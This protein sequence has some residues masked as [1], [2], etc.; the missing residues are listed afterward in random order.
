MEKRSRVCILS[1]QK[2]FFLILQNDCTISRIRIL[3]SETQRDQPEMVLSFWEMLIWK[4][5]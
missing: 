1:L 3:A 4:Q 5:L 2:Y